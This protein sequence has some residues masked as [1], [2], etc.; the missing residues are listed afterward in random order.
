MNE[1]LKELQDNSRRFDM[2]YLFTECKRRYLNA[3]VLV[4][5]FNEEVKKLDECHDFYYRDVAKIVQVI[6]DRYN[7]DHCDDQMEILEPFE[8]MVS[9]RWYSF[10]P[11]IRDALVE[12]DTFCK[13]YLILTGCLK[14]DI[15]ESPHNAAMHVVKNI[16]LR[17]YLTDEPKKMDENEY[18]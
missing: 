8:E 6:Y 3:A 10:M 17:W 4:G 18:P 16:D 12:N 2:G 1:Y 15:K 11:K 9:R 14:N 7:R 5:H 13:C